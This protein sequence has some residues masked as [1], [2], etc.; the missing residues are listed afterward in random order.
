M[1]VPCLI[2]LFGRRHR[3]PGDHGQIE[4]P[5]VFLHH[6]CGKRMGPSLLPGETTG[7]WETALRI[8]EHEGF[9]AFAQGWKFAITQVAWLVLAEF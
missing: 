8:I 9:D 4:K 6:S 1:Q 2:H 3:V 5:S 7:E